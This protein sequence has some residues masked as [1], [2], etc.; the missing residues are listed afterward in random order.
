[1]KLEKEKAEKLKERLKARGAEEKRPPEYASYRLSL[2]GGELIVYESGSLVYSGKGKEKIKETVIEELLGLEENLPRVGCDEAGKG[3]FFGPLVVAC[4]CA[5][6]ECLRELLSLE[7][8][9]SKRVKPEKIK[10]IGE[11]IKEKCKGVVRVILPEVYNRDYR[12]F[13]N[14]NRYLEKV[15]LEVLKKLLKRCRPKEIVIDKFSKRLEEVLKENLKG[16]LEEMKITVREKGESDPVVAAASIVAKA[17]R[18][19]AVEKLSKEL[20]FEVK[21]GNREN[22]ELLKRI[23]K[24]E[25]YR[26]VKLHFNVKETK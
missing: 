4:V 26:F 17:E 19:K 6:R 3:E 5:D 1:M 16:T 20:G 8:K 10:E 13:G 23:P 2:D 15:Y 25:P 21:E 22:R 7:V 9:D 11:K 24:G 14:V 18:L 12:K